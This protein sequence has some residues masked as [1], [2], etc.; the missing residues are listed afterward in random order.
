MNKNVLFY[1][2]IILILVN[3]TI[4][5]A[6]TQYFQGPVLGKIS[7]LYGYRQHP[8]LKK[9]KFH[10]GLDIAAAY[11]T[12]IYVLQDG[13]VVTSRKDRSCGNMVIIE[14]SYPHY[15]NVPTLKTKYCH[16]SKNL[17][18][19]GQYVRRGDIIARVGSTG[20]STGPHLHFEVIYNGYPVE[21]LDYLK[22]L[23][24]YISKIN[25]F[26]NHQNAMNYN[27][28]YQY[29]YRYKKKYNKLY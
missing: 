29:T 5:F 15:Y 20:R 1:L 22:K 24:F 21:P 13:Y 28:N 9:Y 4:C 2:V 23:P 10:A 17:V 3:H 8:I 16:N 26:R 14:H 6:Q 7:S 18:R 27:N 11:G 25:Y 12:P 19:R